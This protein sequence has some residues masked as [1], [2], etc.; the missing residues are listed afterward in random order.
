MVTKHVDMEINAT[1]CSVLAKILMVTKRA[2]TLKFKL[3]CSV[4]AKILMVTKRRYVNAGDRVR[5]VLAK[6]LM[7]TKLVVYSK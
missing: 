5:S 4:L 1:R 3:F 2:V 7:V 6:I